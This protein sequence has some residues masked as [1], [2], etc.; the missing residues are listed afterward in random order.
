MPPCKATELANRSHECVNQS[1]TAGPLGELQVGLLLTVIIGVPLYVKFE[2]PVPV[3]TIIALVGGMLISA[4][5]GQVQQIAW[6]ILFAG[7]TT[8]VF[9]AAYRGMIR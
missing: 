1:Y 7:L 6:V 5:P 4:L 2:D 3:G 8:A 9:G